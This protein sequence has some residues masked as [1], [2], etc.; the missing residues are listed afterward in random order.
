MSRP[1][2]STASVAA[3][4]RGACGWLGFCALCV[5]A[6]AIH[7]APDFGAVPYSPDPVAGRQ[8]AAEL[9][10]LAPDREARMTGQ[11]TIRKAGKTA[12]PIPFVFQ[13]LP[14]QTHWSAVY[15]TVASR[16]DGPVERLVIQHRPPQPNRYLVISPASPAPGSALQTN[17]LDHPTN[18]FAGSDFSAGDLGMEFLH[19]QKQ[20]LLKK[21]MKRSRF[22]QVLESSPGEGDRALGYGRVVSWI[23][24]E[25][26][27]II[28]ADAYDRQNKAL[29]EFELNSFKKIDG[30][31]RLEEMEIRNLQTRT[32][33]RLTFD[34]E[35]GR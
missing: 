31:W 13:V 5:L 32:R 4:L 14:G 21:E 22:C 35:T 6:L 19:W 11:I 23:D 34:L 16:P 18:A 10:A 12:D 25:T 9:R 8:L 3:G 7:A 28:Q 24:H 26:G 27:G 33:T 20:V 30:Q 29:K 17:T 1:V 15:E 2:L